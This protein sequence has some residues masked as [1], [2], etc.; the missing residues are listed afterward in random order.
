MLRVLA[1]W[2]AF[3]AS[4]GCAV[5][6]PQAGAPVAP[7]A[8]TVEP[9]ATQHVTVVFTITADGRVENPRVIKSSDAALTAAALRTGRKWKYDPKLV[10]GVAVAQENVRVVLTFESQ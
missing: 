8:P 5:T 1:L 2:I 10:N 7:V 6:P 9:A 3:V 4:A